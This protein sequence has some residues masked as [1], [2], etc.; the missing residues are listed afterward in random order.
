MQ[1]DDFIYLDNHATTQCDRRVVDAMLPM[2]SENYGNVHSTSHGVGRA[3]TAAV[4]AAMESMAKQ[5]GANASELI[6]TSGA[7]ESNNLAIQG[8]CL[9]PRQ[10][11]RGI[12]TLSTEHPAVLDP[13]AQLRFQGFLITVLP[14]IKQGSRECGRVDLGQLKD[15]INDDT[16]L[17]SIMFANNEIG[18]IQ[19]LPAIAKLCQERGVLLHTDA[20]QGVGRLPIDVDSLGVDLLSASAHKFYGPKGVGLLFVRNRNKRIR[21]RPMLEGGGQQN[22]LRSGTLNAPGIVAMAAALE[23][24]GQDRTSELERVGALATKLLKRLQAE[25]PNLQLNGPARQPEL[26]LAGNLNLCFDKVEGETMMMACP[27]LAISSGSAC[28]SVEPT[29]SHV[30]LGIGLSESEARRSLRI[31]IG[32][33]NTDRELERAGGLLIDAY[34]KLTRCQR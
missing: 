8:V 15:S 27:E 25:I 29:P 13:I 28:S 22:N 4:D 12:L 6:I 30:L 26:R 19:D 32:R 14:V 34:Q 11:R 24:A 21:L 23:I 20:T 16:A 1:D 31:G 17:V 33:F 7:T 18:V 3:A 9:H 2:L 5:L 10:K